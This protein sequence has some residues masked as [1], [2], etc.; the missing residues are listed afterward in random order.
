M[1][2]NIFMNTREFAKKCLLAE[3]SVIILKTYHNF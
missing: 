3:F 2:T 1:Y